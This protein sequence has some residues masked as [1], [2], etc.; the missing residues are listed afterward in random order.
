VTVL[1]VLVVVLFLLGCAALVAVVQLPLKG[2]AQ[3]VML[4]LGVGLIGMAF[5]VL[6]MGLR[7][8]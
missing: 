5:G 7:P 4:W 1:F 6:L 8:W 2:C 3:A